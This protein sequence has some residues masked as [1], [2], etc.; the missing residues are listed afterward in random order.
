MKTVTVEEFVKAVTGSL[1][2]VESVDHYGISLNITCAKVEY[3]PEFDELTFVA[4]DRETGKSASR[5]SYCVGECIMGIS[6]NEKYQEYM[7]EFVGKAPDMIV[8]KIG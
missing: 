7:I 1:V 8:K 3:E 2:N 5:T 4:V 6:Y